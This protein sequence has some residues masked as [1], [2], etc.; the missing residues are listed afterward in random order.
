LNWLNQ[1]NIFPI[2]FSQP[3]DKVHGCYL[4]KIFAR[5]SAYLKLVRG[6]KK[7]K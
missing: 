5:T 1:I 6:K 4:P 7:D 3:L 2:L